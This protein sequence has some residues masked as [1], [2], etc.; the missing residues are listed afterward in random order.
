MIFPEGF[1]LGLLV[2]TL[3]IIFSI[4]QI[5]QGIKE[6]NNP[7]VSKRKGKLRIVFAAILLIWFIFLA[8]ILFSFI[9]NYLNQS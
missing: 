3:F 4:S 6:N 7:K 5:R 1:L 8:I 9:L 2:I